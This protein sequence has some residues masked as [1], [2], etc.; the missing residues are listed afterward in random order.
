VAPGTSYTVTFQLEN[1]YIPNPA[2]IILG[3][4]F[5]GGSG[6]ALSIDL[7]YAATTWITITGGFVA[8][9][10]SVT[11]ACGVVDAQAPLLFKLANF[12]LCC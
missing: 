9:S 6:P 10:S 11:L 2:Q 3:C 4:E 5:H 1:S 12:D 7:H 8:S